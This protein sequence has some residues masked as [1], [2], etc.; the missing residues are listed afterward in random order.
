MAIRDVAADGRL[1]EVL[2]LAAA[3]IGDRPLVALRAIEV[4]ALVRALRVI[5]LTE[6]AR[7]LEL[8]RTALTEIDAPEDQLTRLGIA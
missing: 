2:L 5:G 6:E 3:L 7:L 1:G 4:D 8:L